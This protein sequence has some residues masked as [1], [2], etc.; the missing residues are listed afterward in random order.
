MQAGY[1]IA[2]IGELLWIFF[3]ADRSWAVPPP[4]SPPCAPIWPLRIPQVQRMRFCWSAV[5]ETI[6]WD[7]RH[8]S[9]LP[10]PG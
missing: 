5:W 2:A 8:L 4:T 6:R 1:R 3:L 7:G 10:P 9:S